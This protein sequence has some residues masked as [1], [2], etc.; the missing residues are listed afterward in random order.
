[1]SNVE[2]NMTGSLDDA[3][4]SIGVGTADDRHGSDVHR[5]SSKQTHTKKRSADAEIDVT[6]GSLN[7]YLHSF[8]LLSGRNMSRMMDWYGSFFSLSSKD[9]AKLHRNI[10]QH[11]LQR[12]V[13]DKA[14]S[15]LKEWAR[16]DK[17][18][19]EPIYQMGV[20]L[21]SLGESQRAVTAFDKV[22]KMRP[23]HSA[24]MYRMSALFLKL[25][26]YEKAINGLKVIVEEK[27]KDSRAHYLLGLAYDG[28]GQLERAIESM[29]KAVELDPGE[30]KY[31]QYL[32]FMNVRREDHS[33][34]AEHF[35]KVME[36]ER[37]MEED[38]E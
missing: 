14:M 25:K 38:S 2:R 1:M 12:G 15:H 36:L 9:K 28:E 24:A 10:S 4:D 19:P 16:I 20:A 37:S 29:Q 11:Y 23:G 32:G 30:I 22:L 6:E 8:L 7:Y 35:T 31:H 18:D 27:P 5:R 33:T 34:A 17:N 26:N 13:T 21:A 3:I